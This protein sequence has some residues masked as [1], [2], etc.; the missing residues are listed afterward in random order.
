MGHVP[1]SFFLSTPISR[2]IL[3]DYGFVGFSDYVK[4]SQLIGYLV[5]EI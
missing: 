1:V 5:I 2:R 3:T 4:I